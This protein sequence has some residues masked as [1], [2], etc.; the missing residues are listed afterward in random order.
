LIQSANEDGDRHRDGLRARLDRA[1]ASSAT[2]RFWWRDDDAVT[3]TPELERL[4]SI[5]RGH[6]VPLALAIVPKG[7]TRS[8]AKRLAGE[9]CVWVLQ[10][11][12]QHR[13][14]SP[15]GE[16]KMELGDHR[17]VADVLPE[18]RAGFERL[19]GLFPSRFLPVLVP[20]W[21]RIGAAVRAGRR[22]AGLVGLSTFG[23][24]APGEPHQVNTHVDLFDW[25]AREPIARAQAYSL[26][27]NHVQGRLEGNNEPI[28]ILTHHLVHGEAGWA[29][30]EEI[31]GLI[32][33]HP[34]AEWPSVPSLFGLDEPC[35]S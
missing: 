13:R 29:L 18:L 26:L 24:R 21:N 28:G 34:A 32:G 5:R 17:P 11:G 14:H 7:A 2:I 31:L 35:L 10:H 12:W 6:D 33:S 22:S 20:P 15:E 30:L 19:S 16:K 25:T 1:Q 8:L 23:Q 9:H 3:V 4:L 27:S